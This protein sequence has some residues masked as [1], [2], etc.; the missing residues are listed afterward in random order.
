MKILESG[1]NTWKLTTK[2][3]NFRDQ[4]GYK[5][6]ETIGKQKETGNTDDINNQIYA[7]YS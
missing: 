2:I 5:T 3:I 1:N 4:R 6:M 7:A